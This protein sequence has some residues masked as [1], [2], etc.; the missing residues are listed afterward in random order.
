MRPSPDRKRLL[1]EPNCATRGKTQ[2]VGDDIPTI[3]SVFDLKSEARAKLVDCRG[4]MMII[5]IDKYRSDLDRMERG[6]SEGR[7]KKEVTTETI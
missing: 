7:G 4:P 1:S 3:E 6:Q 2:F 5:E